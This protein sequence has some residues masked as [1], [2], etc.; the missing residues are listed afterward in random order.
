MSLACIPTKRLAGIQFGVL[1]S[2]TIARMSYATVDKIDG[3]EHGINKQG[4]P[5]DLRLGSIVPHVNCSTCDGDYKTDPGHYGHIELV[6]P[7]YNSSLIGFV[8][9][10]LNSICLSCYRIS[11]AN[12]TIEETIRS[13]P[14][15]RRFAYIREK[16]KSRSICPHCKEKRAKVSQDSIYNLV[17]RGPNGRKLYAEEAAIILGNIIDLDIYALGLD[18]RLNRPENLVTRNI[19]V[20]P[21]STRP[22]LQSEGSARQE[23]NVFKL[24]TN[25]V[26]SNNQLKDYLANVTETDPQLIF[27]DSN[28]MNSYNTLNYSASSMVNKKISAK[29]G[30]GMTYSKTNKKVKSIQETLEGKRGILRDNIEGKRCDFSARTVLSPDVDTSPDTVIIPQRIAEKITMNM[31]LTAA[32]IAE[33]IPLIMNARKKEYPMVKTLIVSGPNGSERKMNLRFVRDF[34]ELV[35][36]LA[37]GMRVERQVMDGDTLMFNR[38]PTLHKY[39]IMGGNI[40]VIP[41]RAYNTMRLNLAIVGPLNADFDGDEGNSHYTQSQTTRAELLKLMHLRN[42]IVSSADSGVLIAPIQDSITGIYQMTLHGHETIDHETFMYII[43][44]SGL[45]YG[46]NDSGSLSETRHQIIELLEATLPAGF[47]IRKGNIEIR[48]GHFIAGADGR[49]PTLGKNEIKNLLVKPI[50]ANY[51]GQTTMRFVEAIQKVINTYLVTSGATISINDAILPE[52]L[53]EELDS[54]IRREHE[55]NMQLLDEYNEGKVTVPITMTAHDH[56]EV[57]ILQRLGPHKREG[58]KKVRAYME[59]LEKNNLIDM[60]NSKAKGTMGNILQIVNH[61]WSQELA[62]RRPG[63]DCGTRSLPHYPQYE[64]SLESRGFISSCLLRGMNAIEFFM[65][66]QAGRIGIINTAISTQDP[67][68]AYRKIVAFLREFKVSYDGSIRR[69]TGQIIQMGYGY[70]PKYLQPF[71][72]PAGNL[73]ELF[74]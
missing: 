70:D 26:K 25:I 58:E 57:E 21:P 74:E 13:L 59:S 56:F 24:L 62:G 6:R 1:S 39:S 54:I 34:D 12:E 33:V 19:V 18:P 68:Y 3:I 48:D 29:F 44:R 55:V 4:S 73:D 27:K 15:E 41:D 51:G 35:R 8:K 10:I 32:N 71:R 64:E 14:A 40:K 37:P 17:I 38:Q 42:H 22:V 60:I 16:T 36:K 52:D 28:V 45:R 53:R 31:T 7:I 9:G 49:F 46:S 47:S 11:L 43:S 67:G 72:I 65:H 23:D 20:S 63:L 50:N 30:G 61:L 2:D 69:E 66:A 5:Y